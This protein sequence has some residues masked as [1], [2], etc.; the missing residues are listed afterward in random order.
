MRLTY[1]FSFEATHETSTPNRR[2]ISLYMDFWNCNHSDLCIYSLCGKKILV[3]LLNSIS[4]LK[5][6]SSSIVFC[7]HELG[8][9]DSIY[10]WACNAIRTSSFLSIFWHN[11][12]SSLLFCQRQCGIVFVML[13]HRGHCSRIFLRQP[14]LQSTIK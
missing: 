9:F 3:S 5:S 2:H 4:S 11:T 14:I 7:L 1:I 13:M 8:R 6:F 12:H 10:Y